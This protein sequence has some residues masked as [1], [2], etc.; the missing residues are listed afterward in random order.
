MSSTGPT[1]A[2][3]HVVHGNALTL[4]WAEVLPAERCSYVLGNPPF[5][6]K[7]EQSSAQKA[8]FGVVMRDLHGAGVLDFVTAWY[9]KAARY[10]QGNLALALTGK[11]LEAMTTGASQVSNAPPPAELVW[12][13]GAH[14]PSVFKIAPAGHP[15][16]ASAHTDLHDLV[17]APNDEAVRN[18]SPHPCLPP[19]GEGVTA[20]VSGSGCFSLPHWGR[21]GVGA[22]GSAPGVSVQWGPDHANSPRCAFVSTNSITQGEQV[23]VLWG[24]LLAQGIQIHFAHRTFR[25][26]NEG[27]GVAAVHCVI[28]GFGLQERADKVI[29][30]YD[31]PKGEPHR[32]PVS[33]INPYLVDFDDVVLQRRS[34][35]VCGVPGL[36]EGITPWTT[37]FLL[38][39]QRKRRHFWST[40]H[41]QSAG[42]G[43]V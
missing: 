41:K 1:S 6:G 18:A 28:I 16:P 24:W 2:G 26:S 13:A 43:P 19:K 10:M 27:R 33:R 31:D 39:R 8:N 14:E 32:L 42:F 25:W 23:G 20:A 22:G 11:S 4:D 3:P 9:V 37:A 17:V 30:E 5:V 7:K 12:P 38:F 15:N 35:P 29:F 34:H 40:S 36:V 21:A